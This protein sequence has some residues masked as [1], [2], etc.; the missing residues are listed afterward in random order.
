MA[1]IRS[2]H[3]ELFTDE[4][5][6]ALSPHARLLC[7]G[8]WTQCDDHGIFEWKPFGMKINLLPVD[9]V[10]VPALLNELVSNHQIK[11]LEIDGKAYGAVRNFCIFQRPKKLH[12]KHPFPAELSPYVAADRRKAPSED[13]EAATGATSTEQKPRTGAAEVPTMAAP[14]GENPPHR[15]GGESREEEREKKNLPNSESES[16]VVSLPVDKSENSDNSKRTTTTMV[17]K[18]ALQGKKTLGALIG[19]PLPAE[20][21][22]DNQLCSKVSADFGMSIE[23]ISAELPTFHALNVQNGTMSQDWSATFYLFAKRWKERQARTAPRLEL[24]KAPTKPYEPTTDNWDR[25]LKIWQNSQSSWPRN[26]LGPEPGQIGCKAPPELLQKHHIDPVTGIYRRPET[27][28]VDWDAAAQLY[29][30]TGRWPRDHG[31]DPTSPACQC[32][33]HLLEKHL[34]NPAAIPVLAKVRA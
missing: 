15:S 14:G 34:P 28:E 22:P 10:D 9:T 21:V 17:S 16:V 29:A 19:T 12:Y 7:M 27:I 3:P 30:K 2:V 24:S 5:F 4:G 32:P 13:D 8:I 31:P 26:Q 1:R 6:C 33:P 11:K 20:W 23:Q 18:G 25:A